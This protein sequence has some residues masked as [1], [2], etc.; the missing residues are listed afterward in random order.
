MS[1]R[2]KFD[3]GEACFPDPCSKTLI[4]AVSAAQNVLV[5]PSLIW[6]KIFLLSLICSH[7]Y[8]QW[9]SKGTGQGR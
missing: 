6:H 2:A 1:C 5:N 4:P 9:V 3:N 7:K 8:S